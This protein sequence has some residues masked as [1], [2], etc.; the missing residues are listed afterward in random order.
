MAPPRLGAS[1]A[2]RLLRG[3]RIVEQGERVREQREHPPLVEPEVARAQ[4][5]V[6]R[7]L[8]LAAEQVHP[9]DREHDVAVVAV[10]VLGVAPHLHHQ[11]PAETLGL[12]VVGERAR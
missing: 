7:P 9:R 8:R 4:Q 3:A 5:H 1:V 11:I 10:A 12:A 2:E 6:A